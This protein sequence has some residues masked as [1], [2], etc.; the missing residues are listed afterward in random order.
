MKK[1]EFTEW[2]PGSVNPRRIGWYEVNGYFCENSLNRKVRVY[3]YWNGGKWMGESPY[4]N[5]LR[6][7]SVSSEDKWREVK[8]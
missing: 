3:R 6:G 1:I 5:K 4:A 7:A 8:K 2:F